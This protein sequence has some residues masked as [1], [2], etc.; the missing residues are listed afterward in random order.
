MYTE[1]QENFDE[2]N[3][4]TSPLGP[5]SRSCCKVLNNRACGSGSIVGKEDGVTY[6][7]TNAHVAGSRIGHEV[8]C[9]FPFLDGKRIKAKVIMAAYSDRIMMDWA[10]LKYEG[11]LDLPAVKLSNEQIPHKLYTMGYP[12]CR[13]PYS[14]D[15]ELHRVIYNGVVAQWMG[16]AIGGQSGSGVHSDETDLQVALLTWSWGGYGA[17]QTTKSIWLQYIN[18]GSVGYLRPE[19]LIELS[20]NRAE[21]LEEGFFAQTNITSLPI[22]A[23]L[24]EEEEP[25]VP[26]SGEGCDEFAKAVESRAKALKEEADKLLE[27]SRR[28]KSSEGTTEDESEESGGP[29]FGL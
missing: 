3:Y 1:L 23:H 7:L 4:G 28:M 21:E 16:N 22:W 11:E 26:P 19:G 10:V 18:R 9:E 8:V 20:E 27:I 13:G 29:T 14:Q 2:T 12:R 5:S 15:L 17:G 24:D 6:I 25:E